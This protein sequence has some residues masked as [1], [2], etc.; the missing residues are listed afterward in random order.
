MHAWKHIICFIFGIGGVP[1]VSVQMGT[2]CLTEA[3]PSQFLHFQ[4]NVLGWKDCTR[5]NCRIGWMAARLGQG[6]G[7][8]IS[9]P[10]LVAPSM[11]IFLS[12]PPF[13][14]QPISQNCPQF[15]QLT[16]LYCPPQCYSNQDPSLMPSKL[17]FLKNLLDKWA[18]EATAMKQISMIW[19]K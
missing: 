16:Y 15:S 6:Q 5:A 9:E 4:P 3:L 8:S 7:W 19:K 2:S 12:I 17:T 13:T 11:D 14:P 10:L 1:P 18:A